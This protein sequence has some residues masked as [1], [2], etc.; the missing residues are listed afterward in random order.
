MSYF[1]VPSNEVEFNTPALGS[2]PVVGP[3]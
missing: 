3:E 2:S 1:D